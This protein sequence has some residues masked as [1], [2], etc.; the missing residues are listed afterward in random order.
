M[1]KY[2]F[3]NVTYAQYNT[4]INLQ[5]CIFRPSHSVR[6]ICLVALWRLSTNIDY[7]LLGQMFNIGKSTACEITLDFCKAVVD[8]LMPVYVKFPEG[9]DLRAT[10]DG[11]LHK[12]G[13]PQTAGAIDGTHIPILA[14]KEYNTDY[15][16]RKGWYSMV[17]Q[18]VVDH[19]YKFI[20]IA[21]GWPGSVHDARVFKDSAIYAKGK[22]G[23]L[24]SNESI[25][26]NGIQ[27]PIH[28]IGD[29]AYPL[30][31]WLIKPYAKVANMDPN[32]EH[33]NYRLS[34]ARMVV[35]CAFG[36]LKGRW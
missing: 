4:L 14:P 29:P 34:R 7:R 18:A 22:N 6:K 21:S 35:E 9:E 30:S 8:H 5:V 2:H 27:V 15:Y 20:D 19:E 1:V 3:S 13:F 24:F 11:F 31:R 36:R 23:T 17:M 32:E 33:F 25:N 12:W 10:V 26:I 16:N 28:L